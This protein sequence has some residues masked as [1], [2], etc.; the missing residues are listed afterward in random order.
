MNAKDYGELFDNGETDIA[1]H[2]VLENAQ[3][4]ELSQK[5]ITLALPIGMIEVLDKEAQRMGESC[6]SLTKFWL[7]DKLAVR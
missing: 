6:Q 4:P 3:R 1:E 7:S 5:Q 2:L